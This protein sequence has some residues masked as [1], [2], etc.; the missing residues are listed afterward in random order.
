MDMSEKTKDTSLATEIWNA[1]PIETRK[2]LVGVTI[3]EQIRGIKHEISRA[4]SAHAK[5]LRETRSH[6]KNLEQAY[7]RWEREQSEVES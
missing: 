3:K 1:L 2:R 7:S 4:K 6:L 5:H